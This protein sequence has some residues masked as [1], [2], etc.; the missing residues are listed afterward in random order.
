LLT[1]PFRSDLDIPRVA[2]P[3]LVF[4]GDLD[5]LIPISSARELVTLTK[6]PVTFETIKGAGHAT[7]LFDVDM[8]DGMDRFIGTAD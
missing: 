2:A 8:I 5:Q 4:H 6:A 7:G 1:S 3:M